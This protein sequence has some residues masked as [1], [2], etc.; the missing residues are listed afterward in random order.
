MSTSDDVDFCFTIHS[1]SIHR[2]QESHA[3]VGFRLWTVVLEA[4]QRRGAALLAAADSR[5]GGN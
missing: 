5:P 2:I 3:R 1:Q 4:T